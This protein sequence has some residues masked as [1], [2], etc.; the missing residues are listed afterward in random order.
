MNKFV[1]PLNLEFDLCDELIALIN[2]FEFYESLNRD[3]IYLKN[4]VSP[5]ENIWWELEPKLFLKT[6]S[7][8]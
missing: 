2:K 5:D 6:F 4:R 1:E 3:E 7:C 8:Y